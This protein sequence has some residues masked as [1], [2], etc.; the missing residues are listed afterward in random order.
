M[1]LVCI[2]R[3]G[4][5]AGISS[6]SPQRWFNHNF[7][8]SLAE[9]HYVI[10]NLGGPHL[11]KLPYSKSRFLETS[12]ACSLLHIICT[13]QYKCSTPHP[14]TFSATQLVYRRDQSAL[15]DEPSHPTLL[16]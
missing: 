3:D 16:D 15:L 6:L 4:E 9:L 1:R 12:I 2:S 8:Q 11:T 13:Y 14:E 7:L 10:S 5:D